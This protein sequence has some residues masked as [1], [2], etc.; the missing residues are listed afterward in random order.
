MALCNGALCESASLSAWIFFR[1]FFSRS[2]CAVILPNDFGRSLT[3]LSF[4]F[5]AFA[6]HNVRDCAQRVGDRFMIEGEDVALN[7][8]RTRNSSEEGEKVIWDTGERPSH[9]LPSPKA[10]GFP[11]RYTKGPVVRACMA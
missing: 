2:I 4:L 10:T 3:S 1:M 11:L 9:P 5:R 6:L 7:C 8:E